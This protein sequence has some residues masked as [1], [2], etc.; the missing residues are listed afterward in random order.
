MKSGSRNISVPMI[1]IKQTGIPKYF[2]PDNFNQTNR[3]PE[4]FQERKFQSN[5]LAP[6]ALTYQICIKINVFCRL[7]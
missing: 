7:L 1:L 2:G 4:V 3:D 5:K 6:K